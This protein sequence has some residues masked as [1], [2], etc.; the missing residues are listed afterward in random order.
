MTEDASVT[1]AANA[2]A[3]QEMTP[4]Q[5]DTEKDQTDLL[6]AIQREAERLGWTSEVV[7]LDVGNGG[8]VLGL[9]SP[10]DRAFSLMINPT[11]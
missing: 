4:D 6:G 3:V 2:D 10:N 9:T 11:P 7:S 8:T 5:T 1:Q